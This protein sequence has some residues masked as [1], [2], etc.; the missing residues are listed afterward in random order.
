MLLLEA[1]KT[2]LEDHRGRQEAVGKGFLM[3]M[4]GASGDCGQ[5]EPRLDKLMDLSFGGCRRPSINW[6]FCESDR[7]LAAEARLINF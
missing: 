5:D 4:L 7:N 3:P 2:Q 6:S 1:A